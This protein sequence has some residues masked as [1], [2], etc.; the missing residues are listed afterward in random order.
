[1]LGGIGAGATAGAIGGSALWLGPGATG[2]AGVVLVLAILGAVIGGLGAVGVAAGLTLGEVAFR[3]ARAPALVAGGAAGGAAIGAL[4]HGLAALLL[5]GLFGKDLSAIAGGFEGFAIGAATGLGYALATPRRGGGLATPGGVRRLA[6]ALL[7]G[8]ICALTTA[9]LAWHG[10]FLGAMSL[11]LL[12]AAFPGSEVGLAPVARL[13][14]EESP[15]VISREVVSAWE[16][17]WFG[18]GVILGLTHRPRN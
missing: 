2:S 11:D 15:G 17:L 10:S 9:L 18:T 5:Q 7:A 3:A 14:G 4:A 16:G 8:V 6:A 13:F 12:A 1:V